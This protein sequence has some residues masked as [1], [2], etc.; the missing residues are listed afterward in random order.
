MSNRESR[1]LVITGMH[2]SHTSLV[3]QSIQTAGLFLGDSLVPEDSSNPKGHFE[4]KEIVS[5]HESIL[6]RSD[7]SGAP[8][9]INPGRLE[10][11]LDSSEVKAGASQV[12]Q[13]NF[14]RPQFGFKDPRTS[15]F[16]PLWDKILPNAFYF[17]I[18]RHPAKVVQSLTN[19]R[20]RRYGASF[21]PLDALRFLNLWIL[22]NQKILEFVN[23]S[24]E[25]CLVAMAPDDLITPESQKRIDKIIGDKWKFDLKPIDF[26]SHFDPG[27]ISAR[28]VSKSIHAIVRLRT[29][30]RRVH[31]QLNTLRV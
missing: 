5:F 7:M 9:F 1:C 28:R 4:S 21:R 31:S 23:E 27:L 3:A 22:T 8:L 6:S 12:I 25:K 2:R 18:F 30:A 10:S 19:R 11:I 20:K 29:R 24:P 16:L 26:D 13:K 17:F 14:D 15:L